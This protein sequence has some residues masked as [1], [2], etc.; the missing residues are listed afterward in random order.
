MRCEVIEGVP[1]FGCE[2]VADANAS[3]SFVPRATGA[4]VGSGFYEEA[5]VHV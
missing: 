1:N 2:F 5:N 3:V 4:D